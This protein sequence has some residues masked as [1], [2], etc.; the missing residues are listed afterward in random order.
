MVTS[1]A[2]LVG[3]MGFCFYLILLFNT[4][5]PSQFYV[6]SWLSVG[7]LVSSLGVAVL[8]ILG[9]QCQWGIVQ[10]RVA[11]D[12]ELWDVIHDGSHRE[13]VGSGPLIELK[14]GNTGSF[15]KTDLLFEVRL[16]C[17]RRDEHLTR[18][19]LIEALPSGG[20]LLCELPLTELPRGRYR[21]EGVT[22]HAGDVL[23]L[24]NMRRR[25]KV[26]EADMEDLVVGPAVA[27]LT[28]EG[29]GQSS[30]LPEGA[31]RAPSGHGSGDDFRGTR[32]YVPGDDLR[33]VHWKSTARHRQLV[34]KEFHHQEQPQRLVIWDGVVGYTAGE[35]E[36]SSSECALRL[37]ASLCRSL[38]ERGRACG[39]LRLD[40][41]PIFLPAPVGRGG[42][43]LG[44]VI[45]LLAD[46]D[47]AREA[48]LSAALGPFLRHMSA[49]GEVYLVTQSLSPEVLR[50]V[51]LLR[52][53]GAQVSVAIVDST[54]F[55]ERII[56]ARPILSRTKRRKNG[57]REGTYKE[58]GR[59]EVADD[60]DAESY[61][62]QLRLLRRGGVAAVL[63]P[64]ENE[65]AESK[66]LP[67]VPSEVA[68]S[69]RLQLAALRT[70][71]RELL[72]A[73][74]TSTRAKAA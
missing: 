40:S 8:S 24:F 30:G 38:A 41:Q 72:A 34:V 3:G 52:S 25:F 29:A 15:N 60:I 28:R 5:L 62:E 11:E 7:V 35:G 18:S 21:I 74:A 39:L 23:G 61:A 22:V 69:G 10:A 1:R 51:M 36:Q 54:A 46:A 12:L 59:H 9:L 26:A 64:G 56:P 65:Q 20:S 48:P 49:V 2:Y 43:N 16:F 32:H 63:L 57:H 71:V 13:S 45:E 67:N 44:Q 47:A 58:N 68:L 31:T 66:R 73:R 53:R 14:L 17:P 19:F 6:L 33:T 42:D 50:A 27:S 55:G 70:A 4:N 37:V